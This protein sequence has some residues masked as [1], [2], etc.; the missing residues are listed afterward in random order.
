MQKQKIHLKVDLKLYV[1]K[2]WY[3]NAG[4]YGRF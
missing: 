2:T 4:V 3:A 1:S